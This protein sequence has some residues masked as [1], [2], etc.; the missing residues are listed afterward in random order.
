[1]WSNRSKEREVFLEDVVGSGSAPCG[2]KGKRSERERDGNG[3][4]GRPGLSV[5][6]S[7]GGAVKGE[8]KTKTKPRQKTGPLLKAVNGLLGKQTESISSSGRLKPEPSSSAGPGTEPRKE[9][10]EPTLDLSHLQ[11]PSMEELGAQGQ[12]L[13]SWLDFDD[14][15]LPDAGGDFVGLDVP[16]DDLADLAMMM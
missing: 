10:G 3:M 12:D 13:G 15:S 7:V 9:G 1:M 4:K 14:P 16:P 2:T 11:I 5:S 6:V 8:R